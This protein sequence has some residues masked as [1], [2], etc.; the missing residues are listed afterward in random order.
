M[1]RTRRLWALLF[2]VGVLVLAL[3]IAMQLPDLG[4]AMPKAHAAKAAPVPVEK[5]TVVLKDLPCFECHNFKR[6]E[7]GKKFGHS[8]HEAVGHC[9]KCHT[10]KHHAAIG[11]RRETCK[12]CHQDSDDGGG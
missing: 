7:T 1:Q 2:G 11:I 9:H 12:E 4:N 5:V 3:Q 6:Y 10:F 8:D